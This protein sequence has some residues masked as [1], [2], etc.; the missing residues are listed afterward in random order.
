MLCK[1]TGQRPSLARLRLIA[2]LSWWSGVALLLQ[3]STLTDQRR[4]NAWCELANSMSA[5]GMRRWRTN[6]LGATFERASWTSC[7]LQCRTSPARPTSCCSDRAYATRTALE[8]ATACESE[9]HC[10]QSQANAGLAYQPLFSCELLEAQGKQEV[11]LISHT[12]AATETRQGDQQL[13]CSIYTQDKLSEPKS[14]CKSGTNKELHECTARC[15]PRVPASRI[16]TTWSKH[17]LTQRAVTTPVAL[18]HL[19]SSH[20]R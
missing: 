14:Y 18:Q 7:A 2:V 19:P 20:A 3:S 15:P 16:N 4:L 17:L 11:L 12:E 10:R 8:R 6:C 13:I 5:G 9:G 1:T